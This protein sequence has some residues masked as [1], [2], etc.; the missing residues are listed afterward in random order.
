VNQSLLGH[1]LAGEEPFDHADGLVLAI[2]LNHRVDAEHVGVRGQGAWARA[3]D[4]PAAR[5]VVELHHALGDVERVVVGQGND[6]GAE[7]YALRALGDR[8]Q[9][10]L[11]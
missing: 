8:G 6:A 3:E 1:P 2:A 5:H 11:R 9:E 7:P 4:H 10:Q